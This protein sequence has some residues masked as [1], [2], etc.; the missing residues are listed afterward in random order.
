[1]DRAA[2]DVALDFQAVCSEQV[3]KLQAHGKIAPSGTLKLDVVLFQVV[4]IRFGMRIAKGV[5]VNIRKV[6][7]ATWDKERNKVCQDPLTLFFAVVSQHVATH[8]NVKTFRYQARLG[9]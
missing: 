7:A 9:C 5:I 3:A 8:H 2:T 6:K 1:L 4:E